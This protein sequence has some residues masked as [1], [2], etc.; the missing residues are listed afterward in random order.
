M[1][2]RIR[3][4]LI[5]LIAFLMFLGSILL[6]PRS[7]GSTP[8]S[9]A[10]IGDSMSTGFGCGH[11]YETYAWRLEWYSTGPVTRLARNGASVYDY[12]PGGRYPELYGTMETLRTLQPSMVIIALGAVDY[13]FFSRDVDSYMAGMRQLTANIR[14]VVPDANLLFIHTHGFR[15]WTASVYEA[16]GRQLDAYEQTLENASYLDLAAILPWY[17]GTRPDLFYDNPH[18]NCVGYLAMA[19]AVITKVVDIQRGV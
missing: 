13:G 11:P 1:T 8:G 12:L 9:V 17:D 2:R 5:I 7:P 3:I 4:A 14:E 10:I 15:L 19:M 16:Y 18:F 6:P